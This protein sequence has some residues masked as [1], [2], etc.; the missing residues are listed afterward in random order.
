MQPHLLSDSLLDSLI[1]IALKYSDRI[2]TSVFMPHVNWR[3]GTNSHNGRNGR[4]GRMRTP[5]AAS[6]ITSG[7]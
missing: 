1:D 5:T 2:D 7:V 4:N 6:L 3:N